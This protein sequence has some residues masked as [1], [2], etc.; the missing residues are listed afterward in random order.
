MAG[1]ILNDVFHV[2][3]RMTDRINECFTFLKKA[4]G[5]PRPQVKVEVYLL[6]F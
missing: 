2:Q 1:A 3:K 6:L 4:A 5:I